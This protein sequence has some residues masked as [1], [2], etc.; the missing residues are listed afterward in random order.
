MLDGSLYRPGQPSTGLL[1]APD[2]DSWRSIRAL[3][4]G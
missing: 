1:C 4:V 2:G 3:L